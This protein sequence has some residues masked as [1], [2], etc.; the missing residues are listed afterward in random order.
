[1]KL[2]GRK[3]ICSGCSLGLWLLCVPAAE[4]QDWTAQKCAL[5]ALAVDD[6]L[7]LLGLEGLSEGFLAQ[8]D[9]FLASGCVTPE[10]ICA[11]STQELAFANLLTVMTM[12]E[13]MASTFVPFGCR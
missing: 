3:L 1:M 11:T 13:G 9:D 8:N 6:A 7:G 4:A 12:N 2:T 5:C 10:K